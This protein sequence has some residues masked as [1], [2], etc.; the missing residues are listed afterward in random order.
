MFYA[1][2]AIDFRDWKF[3][4]FEWVLQTKML[5]ISTEKWLL[6][7]GK[8]FQGLEA[9]FSDKEARRR[10]NEPPKIEFIEPIGNIMLTRM[11][12][13]LFWREIG[14]TLSEEQDSL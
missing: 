1:K 2:W 11:C 5:K 3:T 8:N 6:L 10:I 12:I 13:L 4:L 9:W 7:N 14:V